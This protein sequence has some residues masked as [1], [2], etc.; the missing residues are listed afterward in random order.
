MA[1]R[2]VVHLGGPER[3]DEKLHMIGQCNVEQFQKG[4]LEVKVR[5]NGRL[6]GQTTL[7]PGN[8]IFDRTWP[9]PS[10]LA[11]TKRMEIE[12][13]VERTVI[14]PG[15]DRELGLAFGSFSVSP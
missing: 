12:V 3:A 2:A 8:P 11:G 14:P 1:K 10:D 6:I 4:P 5:V 9:L 15:D 13:E 7:K